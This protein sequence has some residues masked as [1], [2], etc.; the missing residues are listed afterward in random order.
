MI[1]RLIH[2]AIFCTLLNQL[3]NLLNTNYVRFDELSLGGGR[4]EKG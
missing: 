4:A 3:L 2:P 1:I